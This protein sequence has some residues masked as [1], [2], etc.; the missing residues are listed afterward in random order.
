MK[1]GIPTNLTSS[2]SSCED[3]TAG[4]TGEADQE[5]AEDLTFIVHDTPT[6]TTILPPERC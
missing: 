3:V 2:V 5:S 4:F 1:D 6:V